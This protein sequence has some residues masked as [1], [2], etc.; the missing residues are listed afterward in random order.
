MRDPILALHVHQDGLCAVCLRDGV[1]VVDHDHSTG[2]IRGLLC[3][4]CNGKEGRPEYADS[5]EFVAYRRN[6]PAAGLR[7]TVTY[8]KWIAAN[9]RA[10]MTLL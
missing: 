5:I 1:L 2:L 8:H 10:A 7:L 6:P 3:S 4:T 9:Y